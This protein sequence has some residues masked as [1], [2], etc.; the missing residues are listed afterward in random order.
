M[1]V[2][3]VGCG[4]VGFTIAK[5]LSLE[6]NNVTIIDW[7]QE[8]LDKATE[9]IDALGIRG[10]AL[11]VKVLKEAGVG[12]GDII[13]CVTSNDETN[14]LVCYTA[15]LLGIKNTVARIRDPEYAL[16]LSLLKDKM[17]IN[18]VINPEQLAALEISRLLRFPTA[19]DID[20]FV[21]G[22]VELV[23]FR[24]SADDHFCNRQ[25]M[26][27]FAKVQIP[28][29]LATV[30]RGQELFI[31][32]G[33]LILREDD[34]V[35][36]LGR[37][38]DV[39]NFLKSMGKHTMKVRDSLIIGGGIMTH[40]LALL[41][42]KLAIKSKIVEIDEERCEHLSELLPSGTLIINADGTDEEVLQ[43]ENIDNMD[44]VV[45]LTDRDEENAIV[46]L[47][48]L[49]RKVPKVITKINRINPALI[50]NLGVESVICPKNLTAYQILRYVRGLNTSVGNNIQTLYKIVDEDDIS[51]EAVEFVVTQSKCVNIPLKDIKFKKD[52]LIGCIVRGDNIII[53]RGDT[54]IQ[55]GD[56]VIIIAKNI[57]MED[58][59]DVLAGKRP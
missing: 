17:G 9:A 34:L 20:T 32:H 10:N 19:H 23:S 44:S 13:I 21:S 4:K 42:D 58:F 37:P 38:Y 48:A 30:Q 26:N 43:S 46:A 12:E 6:N 52:I 45:C 56:T 29:L 36:I 16:E 2:I 11:S 57:Y 7:K 33:D 31:P 53:P 41:L 1:N 8:T 24:V 47:Y 15:T 39:H 49:S 27:I 40:Y 50:K 25:V 59:D 18:L 51:V 14:I 3:I 35:R 54:K 5:E 28:I 22:K 55:P